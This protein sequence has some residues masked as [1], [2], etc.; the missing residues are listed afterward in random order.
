LRSYFPD[1]P[2]RGIKEEDL[3]V[4][5]LTKMPAVLIEVGFIDHH[6]QTVRRLKEPSVQREI[7]AAIATGVGAY[8]ESIQAHS[9]V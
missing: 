9:F 8:C 6:S 1:E 5:R 4:L 3:G 7:A 2:W